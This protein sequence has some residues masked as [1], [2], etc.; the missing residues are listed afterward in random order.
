[1]EFP[2]TGTGGNE[3]VTQTQPFCGS[4]AVSLN[5]LSIFHSRRRGDSEFREAAN[6]RIGDARQ[7][8]IILLCRDR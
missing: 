3:V 6:A 1:M 5:S 7:A 2:I 4:F 8:T